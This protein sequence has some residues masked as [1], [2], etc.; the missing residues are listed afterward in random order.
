M[1]GLANGIKDSKRLQNEMGQPMTIAGTHEL[2]SV[3]LATWHSFCLYRALSVQAFASPRPRVSDLSWKT[4][5]K[6]MTILEQEWCCRMLQR[7][8]IAT[9]AMALWSVTAR[10]RFCQRWRNAR[11]YQMCKAKSF[12]FFLFVSPLRGLAASI[13]WGLMWGGAT[14]EIRQT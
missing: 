6:P 7:Y 12:Q 9:S 13:W 1:T 5:G 11:F 8:C 4:H 2:K 3:S 10:L 14:D